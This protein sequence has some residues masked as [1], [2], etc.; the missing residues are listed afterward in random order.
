VKWLAVPSSKKEPSEKHIGMLLDNPSF[1]PKF[2]KVYSEGAA[3]ETLSLALEE[4]EEAGA[5]G[6][7]VLFH[8]LSLTVLR[9]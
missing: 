5:V 1:A 9:Q 3:A 7:E 8:S 2:D 4:E 6:R